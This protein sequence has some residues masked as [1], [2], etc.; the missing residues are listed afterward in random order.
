MTHF[1]IDLTEIIFSQFIFVG[2]HKSSEKA[3]RASFK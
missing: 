2:V 1:L 3:A